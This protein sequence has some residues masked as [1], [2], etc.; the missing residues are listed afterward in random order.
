MNAEMKLK[1]KFKII[2]GATK[3]YLFL[4]DLFA[5]DSGSVDTS[6]QMSYNQACKIKISE[7]K[8]LYCFC[9]D[10]TNK[11]NKNYNNCNNSNDNELLI[12]DFEKNKNNNDNGN[13]NDNNNND[14]IN[15][16]FNKNK[17][18]DINIINRLY[19]ND[20]DCNWGHFDWTGHITFQN[21]KFNHPKTLMF[22]EDNYF[23]VSKKTIC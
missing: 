11:N 22:D 8:K 15:S 6:H 23:I 16:N 21:F 12:Q 18:Q 5:F 13:D 2:F 1:I 19:V 17:K 14:N 3:E 7:L 10:D 4:D 9:N 20:N